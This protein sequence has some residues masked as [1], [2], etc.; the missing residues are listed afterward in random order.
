[1][2][3]AD[4]VAI[5]L[6]IV[7]LLISFNAIWLL[8]SALW[9]GAV[10]RAVM[11]HESG[12]VKSFF[13][14]LPILVL[15]VFAVGVLGK[16]QGP[17][18]LVAAVLLAVVFI[19]S[20]VGVAGLATL[21]GERLAKQP[22]L[23]GEEPG[24][25]TTIRGGSVLALSYLFPLAGWFV[26]LPVSTVVGCGATVRAIWRGR[27]RRQTQKLEAALTT[28]GSESSKGESEAI[29]SVS[30]MLPAEQHHC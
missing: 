16:D 8:S 27:K 10:T 24:W 18:G 21:F 6:V 29:A 30:D 9:P 26:V 14:G 19:F 5:F 2:I 23:L 7:G 17:G 11:V 4:T 15:T 13:I 28:G 25:K 22:R 20:S 12:L 3:L 1:M